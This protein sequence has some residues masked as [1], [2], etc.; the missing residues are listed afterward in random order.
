M[1]RLKTNIEMR[2]AANILAGCREG[3][4]V[5]HSILSTASSHINF[6]RAGPAQKAT[7]TS[8]FLLADVQFGSKLT[9]YLVL[10]PDKLESHGK[11]LRLWLGTLMTALMRRRRRPA[12]PTLLLIDEAAQLGPMDQLRTAVTLMRGY[13]VKCWSF[14]QD[15]SQLQRIYPL[16]WQSIVNNCGVQ[17]YFGMSLPQAAAE[18][19]AYLGGASPRPM[20]QVADDDAVLIRRGHHAQIVRRPN[21]LRDRMFAGT[22]SSNPFFADGS[23]VEGF[24]LEEAAPV[25]SPSSDKVVVPFP[26][27]G[28]R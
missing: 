28:G 16:D 3:E 12:R 24:D 19:D 15:L 1:M 22:F 27:R 9:I 5:R 18:I 26:E 21:Y 23:R 17:Q 2:P 8:S 7:D 14:W 20:A 10:P 6:L 13:G 25:P 11:L 4:R